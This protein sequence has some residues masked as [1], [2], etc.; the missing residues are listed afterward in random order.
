MDTIK[1]GPFKGMVMLVNDKRLTKSILWNTDAEKEIADG[2]RVVTEEE[3][4]KFQTGTELT[5]AR[6]IKRQPASRKAYQVP[7]DHEAES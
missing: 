5:R 3:W 2:G 1:K 6:K 7:P 4:D